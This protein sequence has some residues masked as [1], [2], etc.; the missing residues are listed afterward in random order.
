VK[1]FVEVVDSTGIK[2]TAATPDQSPFHYL[3]AL[4]YAQEDLSALG[5]A[6]EDLS[7]LGYAQEDL[8]A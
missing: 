7:A 6:Q 4:G 3:S 5:Y 2:G 1:V 8:S